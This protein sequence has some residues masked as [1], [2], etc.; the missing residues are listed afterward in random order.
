LIFDYLGSD[1]P[2]TEADLNFTVQMIGNR[3]A[4]KSAKAVATAQAEELAERNE[5]IQKENQRKKNMTVAELKAEIRSQR[6]P[7][8]PERYTSEVIK[9]LPADELSKLMRF[10]GVAVVNA[11]LGAK[12]TNF[13]GV[14]GKAY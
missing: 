3:L 10:Y 9:N 14:Y 5:A 4:V 7:V 2:I 12:P 8:L 1:L 6:P 13:R 11:R